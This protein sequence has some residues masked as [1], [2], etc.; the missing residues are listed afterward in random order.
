[1]ALKPQVIDTW[2]VKKN[3]F[4]L[5]FE[6]VSQKVMKN[7]FVKDDIWSLVRVFIQILNKN[8]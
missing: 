6:T 8:I 4:V 1:M 7:Y 3:T 5:G 2:T